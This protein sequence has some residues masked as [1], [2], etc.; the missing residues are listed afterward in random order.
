MTDQDGIPLVFYE[1]LRKRIVKNSKT[2]CFNKGCWEWTGQLKN[3]TKYGKIDLQI[4]SDKLTSHAHRAAYIA[5]NNRF[6]LAYDVSHCCHE[7]GCVN[8]AHLEHEPHVINVGRERCRKAGLCLG[9]EHDGKQLKPC[10][11]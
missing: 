1:R 4:G 6:K 8:P 3:K 2:N 5:Y 11:F 10:I 9:H 7:P